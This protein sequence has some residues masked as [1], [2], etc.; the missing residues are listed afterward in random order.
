MPKFAEAFED[1]KIGMMLNSFRNK[2][3]TMAPGR[4]A[5]LDA[6]MPGWDVVDEARVAGIK[7]ALTEEEKVAL[8][9]RFYAA[10]QRVPKKSDTFEGK[11]ISKMLGVFRSHRATMASARRAALDAAMPGWD[12]VKAARAV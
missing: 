7:A 12:A 11:M 3:T 4:R 2:R 8:F 1:K 10:H 6:A 9:A 5:A